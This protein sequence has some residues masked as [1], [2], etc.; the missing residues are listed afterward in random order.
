MLI[1][2]DRIEDPG[3]MPNIMY[4][5]KLNRVR[6]ELEKYDTVKD[7]DYK[8]LM[9]AFKSFKKQII[10]IKKENKPLLIE[11]NSHPCSGKSSFIE[12]WWYA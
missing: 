2:I 6:R 12:K 7:C 10:A 1:S 3:L 8:F 11:I 4:N 9:Q 5:Y